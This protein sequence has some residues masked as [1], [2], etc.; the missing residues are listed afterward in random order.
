MSSVLRIH[1][2]MLGMVVCLRIPAVGKQTDGSPSLLASHSSLMGKFHA[3]EDSFNC[4]IYRT[5]FSS[6]VST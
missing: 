6:G 5:V 2:N 3:N 4:H 1:V